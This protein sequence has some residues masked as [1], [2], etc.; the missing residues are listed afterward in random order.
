[1]LIINRKCFDE[2]VRSVLSV[3]FTAK[4][5]N[6]KKVT[7]WLNKAVVEARVVATI[8]AIVED[9]VEVKGE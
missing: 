1:M 8:G 5:E 3:C 4:D 9:I 7:L 6:G 2:A